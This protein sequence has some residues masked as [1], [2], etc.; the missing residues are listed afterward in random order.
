MLVSG[1]GCVALWVEVHRLVA[2][3][4]GEGLRYVLIWLVR[5]SGFSQNCALVV[6]VEVLPRPACV[7]FACCGVLF[8]VCLGIS[9]QGAVPL[10]VRLA[11][12]LSNLSRYSFLSFSVVPMGLCVAPYLGWFVSFSCAQRALPDGGLHHVLVLECFG[13]VPSGALVHCVVPWVAPGACDSTMCYAVCLFV[14]FVCRFMT[15]LGVGGV[16]LFASGTLCAS[17]CLVV[18]LLPLLGGCFALS[19]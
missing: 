17:L 1:C 12:A 4:S 14:K 7:A 5:S 2:L 3:C 15:S 19:R 18:V 11:A 13:F 10:A 16:E 8:E 6:L 9:G